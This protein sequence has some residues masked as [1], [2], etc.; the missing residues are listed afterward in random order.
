MLLILSGSLTVISAFVQLRW[1]SD[2]GVGMTYDVM[3]A[4]RARGC[5]VAKQT[6]HTGHG[7]LFRISAKDITASIS[8][9]DW[10]KGYRCLPEDFTKSAENVTM[11]DGIVL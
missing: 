11:F 5:Y 6:A 4:S 7:H 10:Q 9:L 2:G 1:D 3:K 8:I